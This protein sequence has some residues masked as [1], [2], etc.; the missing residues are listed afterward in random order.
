LSNDQPLR[1]GFGETDY[2]SGKLREVR[3]YNRALNLEEVR[4]ID[5]LG[6]QE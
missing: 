1:I 4:G 5:S 2:F 6:M 3:V